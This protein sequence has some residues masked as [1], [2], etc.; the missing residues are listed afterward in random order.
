MKKK[1]ILAMGAHP[2]DMELEAGGTLAKWALKGNEVYLLILTSGEYRD[3]SGQTHKT[4]KL[5]E[6]ARE[7]AKIL[8]IKEL[9]F[10]DYATTELPSGG[11]IIAEV[12]GIVDEIHP[13]VIVSHHPFD[14]HQDHRAAAE[15][16][17]AISR[18]GRIKNTLSCAPLP[19]RPNVFAF[20]P[21]LFVDISSTID[22]K[23]EAIRCYNSQYE[24]YG[25]EKLIERVRS[26][27]R[28][29]GWAVNNEYAESFEV[30]R[31]ND[32]FE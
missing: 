19:Y 25:E 20:R 9:I 10:L 16:M 1:R 13:E 24:K 21:Q 17:F 23:L 29:V 18:Q 12:D 22:K 31:V 26:L 7:A 3:M 2:D 30:I 8:D 11:K 28:V 6:E 32:I 4:E 14:S 15:I 27:A 5:K